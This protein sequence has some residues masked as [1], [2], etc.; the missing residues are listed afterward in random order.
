MEEYETFETDTVLFDS[1][2]NCCITN[3]RSDFASDFSTAGSDRVV[4][5]IGKGLKIEGSGTVAW[6]FQADDGMY[7]TLRLPCFFVP[8][9]NTRIASLQQILETYPKESFS[10]NSNCLVL[11]GHD[12]VP[13]LT[14]PVCANTKLPV[15]VTTMQPTVYRS[16]TTRREE[17]GAPRQDLPTVKHPSLTT[18]SNLNL[19]EPEKELLRWHHRLG[20]IGVKRVQWL[21]RQGILATSEATRRM[22]TKAAQ[23]THGP[24][25]TA[26]QYAKQRRRTT[27]GTVQKVIKQE[28]GALKKNHLFP[29]Q[30]VSVDHFYCNPRGRL[31]NTYGKESADTKFMGGCIF[32]DH[33][34]G[35]VFVE[36]QS[37]LT[38]HATLAAK[39]SFEQHCAEHGVIAQNYLTDNGTAFTSEH[40][41]DHLTQFH[42]TIR[43]SGVGAHHSNGVAERTIGSVLSIA[44]AMLHHAAIHWP[45]VANVEL[46]SLAVLHAVHVVNRIPR[47]DSG[48]SPLEL[49][50]RKTW[51]SSKF[52][53]FHVWGCP[54]Y[55]L[56]STISSGNKLPRWKPRSA[57]C[58]YVGNSVKHGHAVP[59]VLDLHTGKIT[60][61]YHVVFDDEFQTVESTDAK[62]VDFDNDDWYQTFGLHPSQYVVDDA[63]DDALPTNRASESEGATQL[64]DRRH[65]RDQALMPPSS[66]LQ[67]EYDP[68]PTPLPDLNPRSSSLPVSPLQAASPHLESSLQRET[69]SDQLQS[70][71]S[72]LDP[73]ASAPNQAV[74]Q[75][76]VAAPEVQ[77]RGRGRPR[78]HP[79]VSTEGDGEPVVKR[80]PGRP[81]N[82]QTPETTED[83]KARPWKTSEQPSTACTGTGSSSSASTSGTSSNDTPTG[84]NPSAHKIARSPTNG[85]LLASPR[86]A[87]ALCQPVLHG[88]RRKGQGKYGP[89]HSQLGP[90]HDVSIQGRVPQSGARGD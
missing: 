28:V 63:H 70:D 79:I 22:H 23:L 75:Q 69:T 5:G 55:V 64:E 88:I 2:A 12:Q 42:Q 50:S 57:R 87:G 84:C 54:V 67:R 35:L 24:L 26:C 40:F 81:R 47:D 36:L 13:A 27:P 33:A 17:G 85:E 83:A 20:H 53:D 30:E 80:G 86:S 6:T 60:A 38:S 66:S 51:P 10:M 48:R 14:V 76:E 25:C 72:P 61:Q 45:D 8:S 32:V 29:G 74:P 89:R 31:L 21:F 19:T 39:Q 73:P 44:R 1:G 77:K 4:D 58:M 46:W 68:F 49:F 52:Q 41:A 15:A 43:H 16:A 56:H 90:S 9:S 71:R 59:L 34:T 3:R 11:S 18:P 37:N 62:Q 78:K 7:R 82:V 65:V